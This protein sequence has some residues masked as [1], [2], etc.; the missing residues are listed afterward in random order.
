MAGIAGRSDLLARLDALIDYLAVSH[1]RAAL[2]LGLFALLCFLTGFAALPPMDRDEARFAQA[3]KQ[4]LES[5]DFIDIRL[6]EEV[7]HKKPVG[8]YWLQ[9]ASVAAAERLGIADARTRI[10]L[11]RIPSL[12]GAVGAVLLTYWAA[13]AFIGR[14]YALLAGLMLAG[15][16]LLGVEA[17]LAKTDAMLCLSAVAVFGALARAYLGYAGASE[18][19]RASWGNAAIFWTA[20]AGS[21]LLKGPVV[22]LLVALAIFALMIADRS[23]RWLLALRPLPGVV[24]LLVLVLPWFVAMMLR[25]Q[26]AFLEQSLGGDLFSKVL[27]GQESHGAPPGYYLALFWFTFWPA[28]AL[29]PL[30]APMAWRARAE[31]GVRFLLAWLVPGWVMFELV[32]T[33][34]PHYV[35]PLYPAAAILIAVALERGVPLNRP[36]RL[37]GWLWPL[38]A[39]GIA[40]IGIALALGLGG[41]LVLSFWPLALAAIAF[42]GLALAILIGGTVERALAA[43]LLAAVAAQATAFTALPRVDTA[44]VAPAL[45]AAARTAPCRNP[46]VASAGFHEPSI[47]FLT[48]TATVLTNG[49]GAADFL[50]LGGCRVALVEQNEAIR[51]DARARETGLLYARLGEVRGLNYSNGRRVAILVL[52]RRDSQ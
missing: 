11:Y 6:R 38:V 42:G 35:L 15:S 19:A 33:K 1:R 49:V 50:R 40:G 2:A 8:I 34:L 48:G 3:T 23:G 25:S 18:N 47:V 36:T 22:P 9:A 5:G 37:A 4:M 45:A 16:V 24:W 52:T 44:F 28:A 29:A 39:L 17:R 43:A 26:G 10:S 13:L 32:M 51:F 41:R 27:Q 30:A 20:L 12:I 14:R 7:R 21:I 31:P 46:M